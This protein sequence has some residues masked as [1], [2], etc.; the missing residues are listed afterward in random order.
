MSRERKVKDEE[1]VVAQRKWGF[2]GKKI[3]DFINGPLEEVVEF[4]EKLPFF[5]KEQKGSVLE[6]I[7]SKRN[8]T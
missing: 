3:P 1:V 8:K 7:E 5:T 6:E 2:L 4:I